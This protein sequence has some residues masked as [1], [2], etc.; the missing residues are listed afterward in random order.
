MEITSWI[1]IGASAAE[2]IFLLVLFWFF[3]RLKRSE[4]LLNKLQ[5]NQERLLAKLDINAQL[6][7]ELMQS[8]DERQHEL[9]ELEAQMEERIKE[10][11]RL[12]SEAKGVTRSPGLLR[13]IITSGYKAGRSKVELAKSTNLSVDEVSLILSKNNFS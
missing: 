3:S 2:V 11:K 9:M 4:H 6:E 5:A 13:E 10:L 7:Q 12:L 1:L 8:F